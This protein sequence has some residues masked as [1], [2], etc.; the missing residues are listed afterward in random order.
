MTTVGSIHIDSGSIH[1]HTHGHGRLA[2]GPR[3]G[4]R[5]AAFYN[6]SNEPGELSQWLCHD[7]STRNIVDCSSSISIIDLLHKEID[8]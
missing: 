2:I 7:D 6:S 5:L 8:I 3:V 1:R 4:G